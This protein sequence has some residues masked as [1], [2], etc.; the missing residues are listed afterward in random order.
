M[1]HP[2]CSVFQMVLKANQGKILN[3]GDYVA[4]C[5]STGEEILGR[6]AFTHQVTSGKGFRFRV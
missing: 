6:Q 5:P 4:K 3:S 2:I 1:K